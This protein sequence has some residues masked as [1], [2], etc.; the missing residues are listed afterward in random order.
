MA[1]MEMDADRDLLISRD[2]VRAALAKAIRPESAA[3]FDHEVYFPSVFNLQMAV[4][5]HSLQTPWESSF[6]GCRI[7]DFRNTGLRLLVRDGDR[8]LW[9][10]KTDRPPMGLYPAILAQF[11]DFMTFRAL[12]LLDLLSPQAA[13]KALYSLPACV[14]LLRKTFLAENKPRVI[15]R[16]KWPE[17]AEC[18]KA[19]EDL[20]G[21]WPVKL[22]SYSGSVRLSVADSK[23]QFEVRGERGDVEQLCRSE[24]KD[25]VLWA[26][27]RYFT[28]H[29]YFENDRNL[30]VDSFY[31]GSQSGS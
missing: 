15:P 13:Q 27:F 7:S 23:F 6:Q 14:D 29:E 5:I 17:R 19:A 20:L 31:F 16:L 11:M 21:A 18:V 10:E 24:H 25:E 1:M 28:R 22:E 4:P 12:E 3:R 2:Q 30:A 8:V 9:S 26:A